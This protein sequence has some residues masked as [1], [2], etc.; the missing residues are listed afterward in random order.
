MAADTRCSWARS[1]SNHSR[2][3][4]FSCFIISCSQNKNLAKM[5][6]EARKGSECQDIISQARAHGLQVVS[7]RS[8]WSPRRGLFE[9]PICRPKIVDTCL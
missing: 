8:M 6:E 5:I 3:L 7:Y 9:V 1:H 4:A 2:L